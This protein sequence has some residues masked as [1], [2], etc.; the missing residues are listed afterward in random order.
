MESV[1]ERAGPPLLRVRGTPGAGVGVG[2]Q[3][4]RC[5]CRISWRA[6]RGGRGGC[7]ALLLPEFR[8]SPLSGPVRVKAP[9]VAAFLERDVPAWNARP[10]A[11]TLSPP[12]ICDTQISLEE[13]ARL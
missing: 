11:C 10:H 12:F 9:G 13:R 4:P 3:G 1:W 5:D 6:Q 2:G 8:S 7:Q